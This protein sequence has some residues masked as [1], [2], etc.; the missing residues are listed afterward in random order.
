MNT[1]DG[2]IG[3]ALTYRGPDEGHPTTWRSGLFPKEPAYRSTILGLKN[4]SP[5]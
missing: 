4:E 5:N 2:L 1:P 3:E